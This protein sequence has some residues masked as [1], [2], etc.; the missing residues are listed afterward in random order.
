MSC[1]RY[2][3]FIC[4]I[5]FFCGVSYKVYTV[6]VKGYWIII[7]YIFN[8]KLNFMIFTYFANNGSNFSF[9]IFQFFVNVWSKINR[10][11]SFSWNDISRIWINFDVS[12]T[13][14]R[15]GWLLFARLLT[16]VII[17]AM[18]NPV[19]L[20]TF[21]GV[22]PVCCSTP[23]NSTSSHLNPVSYTHLTLPTIRLV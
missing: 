5:I 15:L 4:I 19:S 22:V 20:R 16:S 1:S 21:I 12:N 13:A 3:V 17:F 10:E 2:N 9:N 11:N 6:F 8:C 18:T 23:I 7:S 14:T